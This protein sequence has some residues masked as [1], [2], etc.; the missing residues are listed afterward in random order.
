MEEV[1]LKSSPFANHFRMSSQQYPSTD[2][3]K[4]EM[5]HISYASAVGNLIYAIVCTRLD[6]GHLV[7]IVSRFF[8][9][10]SKQHQVAVKWILRYLRGTYKLCLCLEG[11]MLLLEGYIDAY[12][13]CVLI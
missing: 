3:E 10:P 1:K 9:N 5:R 11:E 6:I 13:A 12:M 8:S 4:E 7:G 2:L